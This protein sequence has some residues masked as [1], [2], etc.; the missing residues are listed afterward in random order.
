MFPIGSPGR[1]DGYL[2]PEAV[3]GLLNRSISRF[4]PPWRKCTINYGAAARST[5]NIQSKDA[6]ELVRGGCVPAPTGILADAHPSIW[7]CAATQDACPRCCTATRDA[8]VERGRGSA[9]GCNRLQ[10]ETPRRPCGGFREEKKCWVSKQRVAEGPGPGLPLRSGSWR[11]GRT[12]SLSLP[13]PPTRPPTLEG[14][15]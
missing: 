2:R 1:K 9:G 5:L 4:S 7:C 6:A 3:C 10:E 8:G 11:S 12:F 13:Y 15:R 14:R